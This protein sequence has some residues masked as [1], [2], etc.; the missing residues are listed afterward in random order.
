MGSKLQANE[1]IKPVKIII[2]INFDNSFQY[3]SFCIID[4]HTVYTNPDLSTKEEIMSG[5]QKSNGKVT[6]TKNFTK[7]WRRLL[8]S[9]KR[10]Q[11]NKVNNAFAEGQRDGKISSIK[12]T[13][14]GENRILN[15][16]KYDLG[17][18]YRLVVELVDSDK[19]HRIFRFV[20]TH[21]ETETWLTTHRNDKYVQR[22]SDRGF[23]VIPISTNEDEPQIVPPPSEKL[24][25][26]EMESPFFFRLSESD[27]EIL[28]IPHK[29]A[30]KL[31]TLNVY[32]TLEGALEMLEEMSQIS[33]QTKSTIFDLTA[34][35]LEKDFDGFQNRLE[36]IRGNSRQ[37]TPDKISDELSDVPVSDEF[38]TFEDNDF[39]DDFQ[40]LAGKESWREW[41]TYLHP[42]QY[43]L[44][45]AKYNGPARIRGVS[46]S[47]KTCIA[48]HRARC[49]AKRYN[50]FIFMVTFNQS[51]KELL[52]QLTKDLCGV[53]Q[54]HIHHF[55]IQELARGVCKD[56]I[57]RSDYTA[58]TATDENRKLAIDKA[59]KDYQETSVLKN[60]LS[61][62][63]WNFVREE[64]SFIRGHYLPG[65]G[66]ESYL[67]GRRVGRKVPLNK[68]Q[69]EFM[70]RI[71]EKYNGLLKKDNVVDY[72]GVVTQAIYLLENADN[73]NSQ[74]EYS[75]MP[76]C[77]IADEMQDF[78]ENELRFLAMLVGSNQPDNLFLVGDGAQKIYQR[79]FSLK[80]IGIDITGRSKILKK[81]YRNTHQI[82][83]AAYQLISN[84]NF[85]DTDSDNT[86]HP[87]KPDMPS[88]EGK[89]PM[90][91]KFDS[92]DSEYNWIAEEVKRLIDTGSASPGEI[93]I[94][95]GH[96][97]IR[98]SIMELLDQKEIENCELR[99]DVAIDSTRVKVSTIE[100]AKGHESPHVFIAGLVEGIIPWRNV[101]S[102][103]ERLHASRLY[104][105]MTRARD[106]LTLTW[107]RVSKSGDQSPSRYLNVIQNKC[108]EYAFKLGRLVLLDQP[109]SGVRSNK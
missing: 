61:K 4:F 49:L 39:L 87:E 97:E 53:E 69:R 11:Y 63:G 3:V 68:E 96:P 20:G 18:G 1:L 42:S 64:I 58:W 80:R 98:K 21:D 27:W 31:K 76:R 48:V 7:L 47:G 77:I 23:T 100:S 9:G 57:P 62:Y 13:K 34:L 84:Y 75:A 102:D 15:I 24:T 72:E 74:L 44:V 22:E 99:E 93:L 65:A 92:A 81:N 73:I 67:T 33:N 94:M 106:E 36:F 32:S 17:D 88:R 28:G 43:Q 16:E 38:I 40:N 51:L 109:Y 30:E 25:E 14:H 45:N 12:R 78:S 79:G 90:L 95:A 105:A 59:I 6:I 70:L 86:A 46:G 5:E 108:H 35:A 85:D 52:I 29:D 82:I 101:D 91:I 55:T 37:L 104:V 2:G 66:T 19:R 89:P 83:Q 103:G 8:K 41:L 26:A 50:E 71:E 10:T 60:I 107:S 54:Q 56:F